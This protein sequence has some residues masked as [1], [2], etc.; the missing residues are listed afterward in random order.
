MKAIALYDII[1]YPLQ[2]TINPWPHTINGGRYN[3]I[4]D[5]LWEDHCV[6]IRNKIIENLEN[7]LTV[8]KNFPPIFE[9]LLKDKPEKT[10]NEKV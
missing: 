2:Y 3:D 6:N 5:D 9:S 10:V 8:K 7:S 4:W 1:L